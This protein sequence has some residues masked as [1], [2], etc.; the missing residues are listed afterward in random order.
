VTL[1]PLAARNLLRNKFRTLF[2]M[3]GVAVAVV[4]F[5]LLR[6]ALDAWTAGV[7]YAAKD[8]VVTRHKLSLILPLPVHY[9][10][11]V[12]RVPG[13]RH[14]A[15]ASWFGGRDPT[16]DHDEDF[17][18]TIAV[19][20]A[21]YFQVYDDIVVPPAALERW[22]GDRRGALVG[23]VLAKKFGWQVGQTVTLNG[24]IYPGQWQFT[25]DGIYTVRSKALDRRT[26]F[27]HWKYLDESI[28]MRRRDHIGWVVSRLD[29]GAD[30]AVVGQAIDQVFDSRDA[31]TLSQSERAFGT[32][33]LSMMSNILDAMDIVSL[34]ILVIL[35]LVLGN[36]IALGVRERTQEYGVMR[37]IGF[38]PH[39]IATMVVVEST[40]TGLLGGV[41]GLVVSYPLIHQAMGRWIEENFG[42]YFPAILISPDNA[43]LALVLS[44][45]LGALAGL[46]PAYGTFRLQIVEA[47]RTVD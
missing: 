27:F 9:A 21:H 20:G 32:S 12:Q 16:H 31:Q 42:Q 40:L 19:D 45:V 17:F 5:L 23:D 2:T 3:I 1:A 18:A 8:R 26:F 30:S 34:V 15:F 24:T 10:E 4:I 14:A 35:M 38:S 33:F 36:A 41:C 22:L 13:V 43:L 11:D 28:P 37:A 25:I 44:T 7:D 47:L 46:W 6:T 39:Q 29:P